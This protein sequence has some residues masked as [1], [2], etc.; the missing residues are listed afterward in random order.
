LGEDGYEDC[1][2]EATV[3]A[4]QEREAVGAVLGEEPQSADDVATATELPR[5]TARRRLDELVDERRAART[6]AGK[7]GD[8]YKFLSST[9]NPYTDE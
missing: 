4:A 8:P 7:R 2:T 1:G 6:G 3:R 5:A 9:P